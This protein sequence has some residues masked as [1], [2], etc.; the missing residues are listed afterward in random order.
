L[1]FLSLLSRVGEI[2]SCFSDAGWL[3]ANLILRT[4]SYPSWSVLFW[5]TSPWA[6][7]LVF[8]A[9]AVSAL[10]FVVGFRTRVAG[11]VC[12]IGLVSIEARNHLVIYGGDMVLRSMFF[13]LALAPCG[14]AWSV[15]AWRAGRDL[16]QATPVDSWPL[17]LIQFQIAV[18]YFST[19]MAKLHGLEWIEG[20]ALAL[21]MSNPIVARADWSWIF[22]HSWAVN[23]SRFMTWTVL[24]WEIL[25][26]VLML[27]RISR[28]LA[29]ALGILF[30]LG[31]LLTLQLH[32]FSQIMIASYLAF[33]PDSWLIGTLPRLKRLRY[34]TGAPA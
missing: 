33:V 26:P 7:R 27:N 20:N 14:I 10:A 23:L 12:L 18:I 32:W 9:L 17:R 19:G 11:W 2:S 29:I 8:A 31:M 25:F 21:V 3:P 24:E 15:D 6:V 16:D 30:H 5:I 1:F 22:S 34:G 4:R 13:Y 28:F